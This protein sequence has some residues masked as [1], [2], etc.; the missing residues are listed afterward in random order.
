MTDVSHADGD[1]TPLTKEERDG[2]IP[3]HITLRGELNELEQ[4]N[5]A[6]ADQWAFE[7]KRKILDEGFLRG[8]HRRMFNDVWKWAGEYRKSQKNIGIE[9]FRV[10]PELRLIIGDASYWIEHQSYGADE[11]A[12]RFHHRL[13][14]IH[15]FANGNGR[16]SP[17]VGRFT[18]RTTRWQSFHVGSG[19]SSGGRR[20][21]THIYRCATCRRQA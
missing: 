11:L 1:A 15:P 20:R 21:K 3:T 16:W 2:L 10:Q 6:K 13:V 9:S 18:D 19:Q 14:F 7:R 5:I 12:A 4:K 8:L 17:P